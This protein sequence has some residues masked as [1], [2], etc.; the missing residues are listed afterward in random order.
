MAY[1]GK[2]KVTKPKKYGG[3]HTNV[4]YRSL[5]ERQAFK[6]CEA[7]PNIELWA[8]EALVIPYIC[9]TDNKQHKYYTDLQIK[10]KDGSVTVVEIK[11]AKEMSPPDVT[12]RKSKGLLKEVFTYKKN[13]SKWK[14]ATAY[15]VKQGW[16][17]E[18][19]NEHTLA[20]KGI[21]VLR[22]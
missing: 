12:R 21:K 15:C 10:W 4:T 2:F 19:W 20:A 7:N 3:D 1:K 18:I 11:P 14:Y 22:K 9:E 17:F 5:W 13:I 8:S 6:W 16:K